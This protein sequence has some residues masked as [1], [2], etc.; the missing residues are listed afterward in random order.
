[1]L[2]DVSL[3]KKSTALG[4]YA[5]RQSTPFSVDDVIINTRPIITTNHYVN[6]Y[7]IT[8]SVNKSSAQ[9]RINHV[10]DV[11]NATGLRPQASGGLRK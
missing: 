2:L 7:N 9:C 4:A 5:C 6:F 11:A 3:V 10:A 8:N 1:M